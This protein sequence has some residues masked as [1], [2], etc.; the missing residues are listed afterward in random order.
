[1]P[2][3]AGGRKGLETY[4]TSGRS[5]NSGQAAIA[6]ATDATPYEQTDGQAPLSIITTSINLRAG[7]RVKVE[8]LAV[9]VGSVA[10]AQVILTSPNVASVESIQSFA[11]SDFRTLNFLGITDP[12]PDGPLTIGLSIAVQGGGGAIVD[13]AGP[14]VLVLTEI[15]AS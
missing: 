5:G 14:T 6:F 2:R 7:S 10:P 1:M 9:V 13:S 11:P 12:Q 8:G 15:P 4:P 3:V